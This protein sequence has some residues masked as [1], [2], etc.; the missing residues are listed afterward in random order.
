[1]KTIYTEV[2]I[3]LDE[4]DDDELLDEL[5]IRGFGNRG[6]PSI[7]LLYEAWVYKT[8]NYEDLFRQFCQANIGR[9]F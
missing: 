7:Q 1:M 8:G 2:E 9:S 6:E 5:R 4:F 3:N